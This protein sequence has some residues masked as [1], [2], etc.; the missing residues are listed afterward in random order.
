MRAST[1]RREREKSDTARARTGCETRSSPTRR[2][3]RRG[4]RILLV[5][6]LD[7]TSLA[8]FPL[9]VRQHRRRLI[10]VLG[11]AQPLTTF[12][13]AAGVMEIPLADGAM[14]FVTVR[15]FSAANGQLAVIHRRGERSRRGAPIPR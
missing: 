5:S 14:A 9:P 2:R 15:S 8:A 11:A 6:N 1:G 12:G 7:G 3:H 13:A 4:R 10:D